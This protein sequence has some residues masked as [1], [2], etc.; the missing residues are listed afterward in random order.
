[1]FELTCFANNEGSLKVH[2]MMHNLLKGLMRC[3]FVG[4]ACVRQK[5]QQDARKIVNQN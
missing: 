1:M 3:T 4:G 2:H 5:S